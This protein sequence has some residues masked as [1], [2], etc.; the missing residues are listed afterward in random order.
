MQVYEFVA[1]RPGLYPGRSIS[2][3]FH[4]LRRQKR[5]RVPVAA[6]GFFHSGML[7]LF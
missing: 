4:F 7:Y 6:V 1:R 3:M 2:L 5:R